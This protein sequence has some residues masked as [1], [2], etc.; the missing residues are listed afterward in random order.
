MHTPT[1]EETPARPAIGVPR[2][3]PEPRLAAPGVGPAVIIADFC[4]RTGFP[5]RREVSRRILDHTREFLDREA[6]ALDLRV[7]YAGID[8]GCSVARGEALPGSDLDHLHI[9]VEDASPP[10]RPRRLARLFA[11]HAAQCEEAERTKIDLLRS[12]LKN[13]DETLVELPKD[14]VILGRLSCERTLRDMDR[15]NRQ[16]DD[17]VPW[18]CS[19]VEELAAASR[20]DLALID[21][22]Q[23]VFSSWASAS[24][25]FR[26]LQAEVDRTVGA[27]ATLPGK[28][29][30][31][32]RVALCDQ[33]PELSEGE[34]LLVIELLRA[35]AGAGVLPAPLRPESAG[36][37]AEAIRGLSDRGLLVRLDP[38]AGEYQDAVKVFHRYGEWATRLYFES[39]KEPKL[40][41]PWKLCLQDEL[42]LVELRNPGS[43]ERF[44][45][46]LPAYEDAG[47]LPP[48]IQGFI[49]HYRSPEA[50]AK[51]DHWMNVGRFRRPAGE[52]GSASPVQ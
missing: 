27:F 41:A 50:R 46:S 28:F 5:D 3:S 12:H 13:M 35:P 6:A 44:L 42:M 32:S 17:S 7:L 8:G 19:H 2:Q 43:F 10:P 45:A 51:T 40:V 15:P 20:T 36:V 33:F 38:G 34:Q 18:E 21:A 39:F 9:L 11:D 30:H 16:E 23:D 37:W 48:H 1:P 24:P 52:A 29:K 25:W 14:A 26:S 31:A 47:C 22:A 4:E 49:R